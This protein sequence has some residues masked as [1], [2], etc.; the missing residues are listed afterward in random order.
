MP[1]HCRPPPRAPTAS[2][3]FYC[4][5]GRYMC[6][7][8]PVTRLIVLRSQDIHAPPSG[9]VSKQQ[10]Q[11]LKD[12][13]G[14]KKH[15]RGSCKQEKKQALR[16]KGCKK[17]KEN[18]DG[19]VGKRV[20]QIEHLKETKQSKKYARALSVSRVLSCILVL[21]STACVCVH[22]LRYIFA[23][24]SL[25]YDVSIQTFVPSTTS[26]PKTSLAIPTPQ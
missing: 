3:S 6:V 4:F 23:A 17:Q 9:E 7:C 25:A 26:K 20:P 19:R 22:F 18:K 2:S 16:Y 10:N 11:F 15:K 12:K 8:T 14:R 24:C 13:S 21:H 5:D 1:T